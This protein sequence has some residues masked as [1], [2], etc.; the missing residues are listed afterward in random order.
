MAKF[1]MFTLNKVEDVLSKVDSACGGDGISRFL[2]QQLV[3]VEKD[4]S[5]SIDGGI[6]F[7]TAMDAAAFL[8]DWQKH[9]VEVYG[10]T[11]DLSNVKLPPVRDGFGWG[12][13]RIPELSTQRIWE[14]LVTQFKAHM[15]GHDNLDQ[16]I[17]ITQ[18][19]R[20]TANGPYVIWVRDRVEADQE[21]KNC[22][23]VGLAKQGINCITLAERLALEVWFNWKTGRNLDQASMTLNA[24][25]RYVARHGYRGGVP[26]CGVNRPSR[27]NNTDFFVDGWVWGDESWAP[28]VREDMRTREVVSV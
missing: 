18:E 12:V 23:A 3:L 19:A 28:P 25:S 17:D 8:T 1:G 20:T 24:G 10:L 14:K 16:D 2:S 15:S 6:T 11:V 27:T 22:T 26:H 7:R 5:A 13:V 21:H 9:F 4:R